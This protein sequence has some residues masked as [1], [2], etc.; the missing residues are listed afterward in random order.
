VPTLKGT[1]PE[2][3]VTNPTTPI[4][5]FKVVTL[6]PPAQ[7]I[8]YYNGVA[9]VAGDI[10]GTI[11]VPYDPTKLTFDP[12]DGVVN[13]SFTYAS[14]DAA[15]KVDLSPA[16]AKMDFSA[17]PV[18]ISGTV[19]NDLDSSAIVANVPGFTNIKTGI[20]V[21]TNAVFGTTIINDNAILVDINSGKVLQSVVVA[22]DGTYSFPG[23]TANT[24]VKILLSP[25]PGNIGSIPPAAAAPI[26]WASTSPQDAGT[27]N[28]GLYPITGKDFGI[29]QK[30]KLVLYKLITKVNGQTINP[31]DGTNLTV[32]ATDTFNNVGNWPANYLVGKTDAGKVQ[33][34]DTLEYTVYFLNNQGSDATSV[35]ICDP[36]HGVQDYVPN[37]IKLQLAGAATATS[38]SDATDTLDRA[39]F[40]AAGNTPTNCN[41][42]SATSTGVDK[43]GIAIGITGTSTTNQA[44]LT[45]IP[46][47]TGVATPSAS[48][49]LFR[50]TTKVQQ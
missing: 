33:P 38:L 37:S 34:G 19:W 26:G 41:A 49:G 13:M 32:V 25:T 6:P 9:V 4:T 43:G 24:D 1:D 27:F 40:Y 29:R 14:V 23:V 18:T 21:G 39:N 12:V 17:T 5:K 3:G 48:Y 45:G 11:T 22:T 31:N 47:A 44:A 7:G 50:F 46:G 2:D 42:I 16:I 35:K 36:I 20:E 10:L 8:L 15:G 28:A 30:A